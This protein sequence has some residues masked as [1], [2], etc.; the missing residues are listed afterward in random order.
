MGKLSYSHYN[1][2]GMRITCVRPFA[3][4]EKT[5]MQRRM[6][7]CL[8]L[9][10]VLAACGSPDPS[11]T[12]TQGNTLYSTTFDT[13]GNWET[14]TYP[15]DTPQPESV[16]AVKDGHYQ[17]DHQAKSDSSFVWGTG[18]DAYQNVIIEVETNQLSG[19]KDDLYGVMCRLGTD[20]RGNPNGYA[21]LISGDGHFGIADFSRSSLD[22]LLKWH[23][24]ADLKQGRAK[25]TI[26]A[27][28]VDNYLALYANG[29]FLGD[30][31]DNKYLR[32]GQVGLV[33]GITKKK[34]VSISFD[35]LTVYEGHQ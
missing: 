9:A 2:L 3:I 33:A 24:S 16:L 13:P 20:E 10:L 8:G 4:R 34:T 6:I 15:P 12:V 17:I 19:E 18:G 27:V 28:C 31:K 21:L 5:M 32:A 11:Q 29:K 1:L 26:R 30:A 14:G 25:N 23:E 35:N 22:F 7:W